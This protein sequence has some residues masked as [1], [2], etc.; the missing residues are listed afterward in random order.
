MSEKHIGNKEN[1]SELSK[2]PEHS[3]GDRERL[4]KAK[5]EAHKAAVE[6][7]KVNINEILEKAKQAAETTVESAPART[8]EDQKTAN[9]YWFSK[10]YRDDS[11][12]QLIGSVQSRLSKSERVV[13]KLIH[14][15][16]VEKVSEIG[17]RTVARPSG[18]LFGSISSFLVS[19]ITYVVARRNGYDMTYSVFI[20]SFFGGFLIGIAAEY[21]YKLV[22]SVVSRPQ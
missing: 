20:L 4:E 21:G 8:D 5:H 14:Q 16:I 2:S 11:Y 3:P 17:S 7:E 18:L 22:R 19:M 13:S 9:T 1:N 12:K 6:H 15:P 10:Q